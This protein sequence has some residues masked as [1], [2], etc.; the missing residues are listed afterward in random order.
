MRSAVLIHGLHLGANGWETL[1]WGD[2][3]R[4]VWGTV[5][6]GVEHA[7][8][9]DAELVYWGSGASEKEGVKE[10]DAMY[11]RALKD[12]D[13]LAVLC[14][15]EPHLLQSFLEA[16]SVR[17]A[18]AKDT[19]AE[20]RACF[21]LCIERALETVVLVPCASQAPIA[22][23]RAMGLVLED[24]VFAPLRHRV[25]ILPSDTAYVGMTMQDIVIFTPPHRGDRVA[26]PSHVLARRTLDVIQKFSKAGD[27][28][29]VAKVLGAWG[30]FLK[31]F[32]S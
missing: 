23:R 29:G 31:R 32:E 27:A 18:V 6:R 28:E 12:I 22:S 16:R 25:S 14:G 10:C 11:D 2:L 1:V 15:T 13:S 21:T 30:D 4:G 7:W 20:I 24:A 9:T 17:D 5:P 8:R 19:A 3:E 26:N